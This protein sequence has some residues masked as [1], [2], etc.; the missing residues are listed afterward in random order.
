MPVAFN[1]AEQYQITVIVLTDKQIADALYTQ[2]PYDLE[3][4]EIHRGKLVTDPGELKALK[5]SDRY[6]AGAEAGIS[7][8]WLPGSEAATYC[9]QGDEHDSMGAVDETGANNKAQ[10]EKRM[11]KFRNAESRPARAAFVP[12]R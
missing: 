1:L 3:K 5:A 9:A 10:T 7:S 6:D 12:G 2:E 4:A 11:R 8:R